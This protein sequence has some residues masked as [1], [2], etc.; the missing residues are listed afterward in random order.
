MSDELKPC[1]FCGGSAIHTQGLEPFSDN[2]FIDCAVCGVST[3][4]FNSARSAI[5]AWNHR[6]IP[7]TGDAA[8]KD[9]VDAERYRFLRTTAIRVQAKTHGHPHWLF[10]GFEMRGATFDDALDAAIASLT[11]T[12]S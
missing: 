1:P 3:K 12:Q 2:H 10:G 9:S 11:K 5:A 4:I 6:A 7:P 8:G